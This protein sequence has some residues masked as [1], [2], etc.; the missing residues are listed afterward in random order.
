MVFEKSYKVLEKLLIPNNNKINNQ[1][2]FIELE[3]VSAKD[4]IYEV[5]IF[6]QQEQQ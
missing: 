5:M 2:L 4:K 6:F 3:F 1:G